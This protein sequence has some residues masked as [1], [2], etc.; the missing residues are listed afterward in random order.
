[1]RL[2]QLQ[3]HLRRARIVGSSNDVRCKPAIIHGRRLSTT[4]TY[5]GRG[6]FSWNELQHILLVDK[7]PSNLVRAVA[8][9]QAYGKDQDRI[10]KEYASLEDHLLCSLFERDRVWDEESGVWKA[11]Q[12]G[13]TRMA[14]LDRKVLMRNQHPYFLAP[15]IDQWIL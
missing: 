8:D 14:T 3:F 4:T 11:A 15:G 6:P 9:E 1:M 13:S 10:L 2:S 12:D 5:R 7:D